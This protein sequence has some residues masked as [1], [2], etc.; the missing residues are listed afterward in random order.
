[1]AKMIKHK[2]SYFKAITY[3]DM[4]K[5]VTRVEAC[6]ES[7]TKVHMTN[8]HGQDI[9]A[10]APFPIAYIVQNIEAGEYSGEISEFLF[11]YY[12]GEV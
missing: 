7:S 6:N 10:K 11:S 8:L 12:I 2:D 4:L 5:K 1:M 9:E 3:Y